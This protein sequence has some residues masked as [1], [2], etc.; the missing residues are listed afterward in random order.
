VTTIG[1]T[2]V[3]VP[4]PEGIQNA[5]NDGGARGW[6][7]KTFAKTLVSQIQQVIKAESSSTSNEITKV[8]QF[9]STVQYS[10]GKGDITVAYQALLINW[11]SDLLARLG[12]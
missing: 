4:T 12:G 6:I 1:L 2:F 5:I 3:I 11:A 7:S 9:I 8:K 10:P